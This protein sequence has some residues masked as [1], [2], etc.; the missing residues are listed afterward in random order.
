ME[1][2]WTCVAGFSYAGEYFTIWTQPIKN[3]DGTFN[4]ATKSEKC[5]YEEMRESLKE[6]GI[7]YL[8]E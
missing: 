7:K 3:S 6:Q 4:M 1:S 2:D 8:A 5:T